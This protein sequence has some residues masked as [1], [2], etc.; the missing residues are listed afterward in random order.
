M[1]LIVAQA[2][3]VRRG[4]GR[5]VALAL[6]VVLLCTAAAAQE[7]GDPASQQESRPPAAGSRAP[8][9]SIEEIVVLGAESEGAEDFA[10][11]DSVTGFGAEDLAALGAQ[12]VA[13]LAAFTPNLEIVTSGATTPTFFI[14]GVGL[15]DFN[16]NSTGAVAVYQDDVP[17]NAPALQLGTLFDVEAVNILRGPQGTGQSRNASAGAIKIY[18]R[19]PSGEFGGFVRS[20]F[21]NY[22]YRDFEGAFEA[23]IFEDLLSG[24]FAFRYSDRDGTMK[25]RCHGAPEFG[26]RVEVPP[27]RDLLRSGKTPRDKP[28]SICGEPVPRRRNTDPNIPDF[29]SDDVPPG[30]D[31]WLNDLNNWAARGTVLFEPTLDLSFLFNAHGSRR[32]E[33]SRVGQSYGVAGP[34]SFTCRNNDFDNCGIGGASAI[35]GNLSAQQGGGDGYR[36]PEVENALSRRAPCRDDLSV[37]RAFRCTD[38]RENQI[39]LNE[40]RLAVASDIAKNLDSDP[41][42]GDFNRTGKTKNDTYGGYIKADWVLPFAE[43]TSISSIDKYDRTIDIDLDFSPV[44]LFHVFTDDEGIQY[45]Q[46]VSLKGRFAEYG[47]DWEIGGYFLHEELEV[48]VFNDLGD[49]QAFGVGFREYTQKIY[50]SAGYGNISWDFWDRFTLDGGF[51]FNWENK[52]LNYF[53][54]PGAGSGEGGRIDPNQ[55]FDE[56]WTDPTG[57]IRLT[58]RFR[59]DTHVFA[60]YTRGFKPGHYNATGSPQTGVTIADP[61]TIDSWEAGLRGSWLQGRIGL[62]LSL[63][64]YDYSEYQIFT[65]QQLIGS[66]PEFVV[67][68]ANDAEVYGAEVDTVLR[69]W[70]GAFINM[71][72]AW[73]ESQFL[74][75]TQEQQR[76]GATGADIVTTEV[77]NSGNRLL[78]SP[79]YKVSITAEQTIPLGRYGSLTPRYDG[80]WTDDTHY[81]PTGGTGTPNPENEIFLPDNAIGQRAYWLHNLR[82]SYRTPAGDI[83]IAGWIRN[84]ADE[85]YKTFAFDATGEPFFTTIAFV[86][87][88]RMYGGT[89]VINF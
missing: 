5:S 68:N 60:K 40:A 47:L 30:L 57:T 78:N 10:A 33:F 19:K 70:Q 11:G 35:E 59:E 32:D 48:E 44:T 82:L 43:F 29:V 13:D 37:P 7:A 22:D 46:N 36:P 25:N 75:F 69:P 81:D 51:R 77:D 66:S 53:L 24:R 21:G 3:Y 54:E 72:F 63:F 49:N 76:F 27:R 9:S 34:E 83:E 28:W 20:D 23:P 58:Y 61:E 18:A 38:S 16:S 1:L 14:R 87:D 4:S 12:D 84:L 85:A 88:R 71:R 74:D 8:D 41:W 45:S 42:K 2:N 67:L 86:G 31:E 26:D 39:R 15:N 62:D 52:T 79:K 6:C 56:D 89:L 65:V 50:S 73:L 64:Y 55:A 17:V 80:V